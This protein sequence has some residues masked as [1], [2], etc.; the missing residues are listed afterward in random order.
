MAQGPVSPDCLVE[1]P[2]VL[3]TLAHKGL[4]CCQHIMWGPGALLLLSLQVS[5]HVRV[6]LAA[7][8]NNLA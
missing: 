2:A 6:A 3:V 8:I 4:H 5:Q 1:C 7:Q